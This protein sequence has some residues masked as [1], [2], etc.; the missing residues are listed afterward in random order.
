MG[1]FNPGRALEMLERE[2]ATATYPSF[3]TIMADLNLSP[4]L[5]EDGTSRVSGS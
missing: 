2:K 4:E 1:Y 5:Q 3:V